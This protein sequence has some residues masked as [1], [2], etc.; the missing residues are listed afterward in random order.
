M[1]TDGAGVAR[2]RD[3]DLRRLRN[4]T[5]TDAGGRAMYLRPAEMRERL[6]SGRVGVEWR[7]PPRPP[8]GALREP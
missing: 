6:S 7:E 4:L 5:L 1:A 3:R 2:F 8:Q